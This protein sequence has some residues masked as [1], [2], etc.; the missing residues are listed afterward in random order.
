MLEFNIINTCFIGWYVRSCTRTGWYDSP[1]YG[2]CQITH[3][4]LLVVQ[5]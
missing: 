1:A 3:N 5:K 2:T 4:L